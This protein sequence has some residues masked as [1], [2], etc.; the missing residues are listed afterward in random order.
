MKRAL[1]VVG[2]FAGLALVLAIIGALLPVAH[3]ARVRVE[4]R[5]PP[6]VVYAAIADVAAYPAWR[7]DLDSLVVVSATPRLRW[8]ESS[9]Q[10]TIEFE[11]VVAQAPRTVTARIQGAEEQ[12]FGGSWTWELAPKPEGGTIL[13]ITEQGEVYNPLFRLMSHLFFSPYDSLEQYARDL[14]AR[15]GESAHTERI[16]I[17]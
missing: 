2:I 4:L 3:S 14:A 1:I 9:A 16:S 8:R 11:Q 5:S 12:G 15:F 13:T 7:A 17:D 6:P 10:G